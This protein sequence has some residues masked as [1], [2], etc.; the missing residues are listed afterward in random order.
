MLCVTSVVEGR[1]VVAAAS[2]EAPTR[3]IPPSSTLHQ[4][5]GKEARPTLLIFT[6]VNIGRQQRYPRNPT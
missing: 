3:L 4:R 1:A 6:P 2:R 5:P